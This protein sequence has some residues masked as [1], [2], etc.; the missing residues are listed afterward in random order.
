[1]AWQVTQ[2]T[3]AGGVVATEGT[4][5]GELRDGA[6]ALIA[7]KRRTVWCLP[8]GHLEEGETPEEAALREVREET[9]LRAEILQ[10]LGKIS[11][12]FVSSQEQARILKTVHFFLMRATGGSLED[13]DAEA[14][15]AQWFPWQEALARMTYPS[16]RALV[17]K[18]LE[19]VEGMA[20]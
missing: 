9:G 2:Q 8:K 18:A 10:S 3:S 1:M 7:R 15:E 6:V 20:E 19:M 12:G 4:P 5:K 14:E 13:H 16:E 17:R 11:Y